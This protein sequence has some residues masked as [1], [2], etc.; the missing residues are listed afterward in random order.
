MRSGEVKSCGVVKVVWWCKGWCG[1]G[2]SGDDGV[3][4]GGVMVGWMALGD[5]RWRWVMLG[6]VG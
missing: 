3:G 6:G 5:V 1:E 4:V 2:W